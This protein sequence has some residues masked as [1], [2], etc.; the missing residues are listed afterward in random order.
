MTHCSKLPAVCG[1]SPHL[2]GQL[3]PRRYGEGVIDNNRQGNVPAWTFVCRSAHTRT[4]DL[5]E[6]Q[7]FPLH[8]DGSLTASVRIK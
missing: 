3:V 6:H 5:E 4:V 1:T 7:D 8:R 2:P